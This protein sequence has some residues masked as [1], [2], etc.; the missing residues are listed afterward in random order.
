MYLCY[1]GK[2]YNY[3]HILRKEL[4]MIYN[5]LLQRGTA[6]FPIEL[7][8]LDNSHPRYEMAAHWHTDIELMRVLK[9]QLKVRLD[10]NEYLAQEGDIIF[11]N[12]ETVHSAIPN[13]GCVYQCIVM[14][15]DKFSVA[16]PNC[17]FFIENLL[18]REVLVKEYHKSTKNDIC[19]SINYLFDSLNELTK[20]YK[21]SVVSALYKIL[22]TIIDQELFSSGSK[23]AIIHSSNI[24]TLK[25]VLSYMRENYDKQISLEDIA[26]MAEMSPKYFCV[27]FKNITGKTPFEYLISYRIEC[28]AR[29]LLNTNSSVTEIALSCGFND[30]SYFIKTFKNY[31]GISPAKFRKI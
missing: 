24:T 27:F 1:N 3:I 9:G 31:K 26:E 13:A 7:Y 4:N 11:V 28:S 2:K 10:T 20:G 18:S 22:A 16:D 14:K 23:S 15:F 5:E 6:E 21:F 25:N 30:L 12:S 19:D 29:K 17:K 8:H